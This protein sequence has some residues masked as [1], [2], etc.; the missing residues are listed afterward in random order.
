MKSEQKIDWNLEKLKLS[1]DLGNFDNSSINHCIVSLNDE[2]HRVS[3]AKY[4]LLQVSIVNKVGLD[5]FW[6]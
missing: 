6:T 3:L 4:E 5:Q 2:H 1:C